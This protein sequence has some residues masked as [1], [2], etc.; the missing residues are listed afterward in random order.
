[1]PIRQEN[2]PQIT[3]FGD[4]GNNLQKT[5]FPFEE[6]EKMKEQIRNR[7]KQNREQR[8]YHESSADVINSSTKVLKFF[9]DNPS[10]VNWKVGASIEEIMKM[11]SIGIV[12]IAE[13][14]DKKRKKEKKQ[15]TKTAR[16][17][18]TLSK[19]KLKWP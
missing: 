18:N 15:F 4:D 3:P 11:R 10:K 5:S 14:D 2:Q 8:G 13:R 7:W 19:I 16:F 6:E 1:M 17:M 12:N 9:G